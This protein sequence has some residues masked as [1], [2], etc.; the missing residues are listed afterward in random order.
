MGV[1]RTRDPLAYVIMFEKDDG[2]RRYHGSELSDGQAGLRCYPSPFDALLDISRNPAVVVGREQSI[3]IH[4]VSALRPGPEAGSAPN[5]RPAIPCVHVAWRARSGKLVIRAD[6]MPSA[7][8]STS[9][10]LTSGGTIRE[11]PRGLLR[12][13]DEIHEQAG[14]FAWKET[15]NS[16]PEW[17]EDDLRA[18]AD[19]AW[20]D[21]PTIDADGVEPGFDQF[22]LYDP[23]FRQWHFV[24][25]EAVIARSV[26]L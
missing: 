9:P 22:A 19:Q 5:G 14:L 16:F 20:R 10:E 11:F 7:V 18:L 25:A 23:E 21:V 26:A 4:P 1:F 15:A 13:V 3:I 24:E 2:E 6:G 17:G 12:L 8:L